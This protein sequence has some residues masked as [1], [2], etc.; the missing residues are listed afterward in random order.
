MLKR[1]LAIGVTILM[2]IGSAGAALAAA[3]T[4][5][6]TP[7]TGVGA[8]YG[9]RDPYTCSATIEPQQGAITADL[10]RQYFI[11]KVEQVN[12]SGMLFLLDNVKV[13]VGKK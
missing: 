6:L 3:E 4:N 7:Q 13:E 10:A 9:S 5:V 1:A 2:G 11:C 12:G 8:K